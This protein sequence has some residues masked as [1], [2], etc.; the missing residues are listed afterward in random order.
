[1]WISISEIVSRGYGGGGVWTGGLFR[2]ARA[3]EFLVMQDAEWLG[4]LCVKNSILI[5]VFQ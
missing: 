1:M 3:E 5:V 4:S 2:C